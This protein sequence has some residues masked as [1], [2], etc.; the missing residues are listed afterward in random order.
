M[1]AAMDHDA[2]NKLIFAL[3]SVQADALRI[4][5]RG[6]THLL[7]LD[8]LERVS[9]EHPAEDLT[10]RVGDLAWRVRF[11]QGAVGDGEPPWLLVPTECQ[12]GDDQR[13][14]LR[15]REYVE[16]HLE[17]LRREGAWSREGEEPLVLPLVVYDGAARWVREAG[18]LGRLP[19]SAALAL[20]PLQPGRYLL[21][22]AGAWALEDWPR[23]NRVTA[24]VRLLRAGTAA[25]LRAALND[26]LA[27]FSGPGDEGFRRALRLWALALLRANKAWSGEE[28]AAFEDDQGE[29]GMTSLVEVNGRKIREGLIEQGRTEGMERGMERGR[30]EGIRRGRSEERERLRR[31]LSAL[32]LDAE[33]A[34]RVSELLDRGG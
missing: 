14:G 20:A 23:G 4:V 7:D 17:A 25:E 32:K 10:Q 13:M 30:A 8:T 11:R 15:V 5:T 22:D 24:W 28:L 6:W 3:P 27:E 16:R 33:A 9:A 29:S 18:P 1:G 19:E 12:S 26:G 2:L 21:L 31:E 34:A